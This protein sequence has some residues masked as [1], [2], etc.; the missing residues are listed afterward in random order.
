MKTNTI[1]FVL[2]ICNKNAKTINHI[3]FSWF[4]FWQMTF[5]TRLSFTIE[6]LWGQLNHLWSQR[7]INRTWKPTHR[8]ACHTFISRIT[9]IMCITWNTF[10][11]CNN[12]MNW[13]YYNS[14]YHPLFSLWRNPFVFN[15]SSGKNIR[16]PYSLWFIKIALQN[17]KLWKQATKLRLIVCTSPSSG[18]NLK[19]TIKAILLF[20]LK[21]SLSKQY[22]SWSSINNYCRS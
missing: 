14:L 22:I 21:Q 11:I 8:C 17:I 15:G 2:W 9:C 5:F 3:T 12:L 4:A 1:L 7:A 18:C 6:R 10:T 20:W 13:A 19:L 16:E